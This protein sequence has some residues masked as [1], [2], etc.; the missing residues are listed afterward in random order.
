MLHKNSERKR[1][2]FCYAA[3]HIFNHTQA[4]L[5]PGDLQNYVILCDSS[6]S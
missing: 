4:T 1:T 2:E 3:I 5:K 6:Q